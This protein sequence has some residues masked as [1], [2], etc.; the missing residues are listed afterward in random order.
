LFSSLLRVAIL[1]EHCER[2]H[3]PSTRRPRE[4]IRASPVASIFTIFG[5]Y[6]R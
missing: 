5:N 1:S 3:L 6:A 2:E 4:E